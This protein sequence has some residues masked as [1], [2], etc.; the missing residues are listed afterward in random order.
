M[1]VE[2]ELIDLCGNNKKVMFEKGKMPGILLVP[3]SID[4]NKKINLTKEK[5]LE[6][7]KKLKN[8]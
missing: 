8:K 4:E 5:I 3:K 1:S 6:M 2:L 7:V